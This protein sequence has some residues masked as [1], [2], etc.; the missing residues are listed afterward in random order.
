M[1]C[2]SVTDDT[3]AK[4]EGKGECIYT[5]KECTCC[6]TSTDDQLCA[7]N[8]LKSGCQAPDSKP[9]TVD[10]NSALSVCVSSYLIFILSFLVMN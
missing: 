2:E 3:V 7:F 8:L 4:C 10:D 5:D 1:G 6:C 9:P